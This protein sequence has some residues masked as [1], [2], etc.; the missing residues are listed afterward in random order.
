MMNHQR[1]RAVAVGIGVGLS[2]A[3]ATAVVV[4]ATGMFDEP[5]TVAEMERD[6]RDRGL[7]GPITVISPEPDDTLVPFTHGPYLLVPHGWQGDLPPFRVV[8]APV[9]RSPAS[10]DTNEVR[11]SPLWRDASV[12]TGFVLQRAWTEGLAVEA[13]GQYVSAHGEYAFW[14]YVA[15]PQTRPIR[16]DIWTDRGAVL[17]ATTEVDG[18]PAITW[19]SPADGSG[20]I[21]AR[22]FDSSTGIEYLVEI[23]DT[24]ELTLDDAIDMLRSLRR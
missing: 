22:M 3:I 8:D 11:N 12:P 14:T 16:V 23:V 19:K 2:L 17:F 4:Q 9:G 5:P 20:V 15:L 21:G 1:R 13:R 24:R 10:D 18:L 7:E 6:A